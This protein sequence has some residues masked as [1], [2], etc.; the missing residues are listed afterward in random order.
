MSVDAYADVVVIGG[1]Q[2]AHAVPGV[3]ASSASMPSK[4]FRYRG[5]AWW[6]LEG[7]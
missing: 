7:P 5:R 1:G 6:A 4:S 2:R 3:R